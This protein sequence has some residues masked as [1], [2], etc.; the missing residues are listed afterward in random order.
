MIHA[1][2]TAKPGLETASQLPAHHCNDHNVSLAE[3]SLHQEL[4]HL[5]SATPPNHCQTQIHSLLYITPPMGILLR[6][7]LAN[8]LLNWFQTYSRDISSLRGREPLN[9][10]H[11]QVKVRGLSPLRTAKHC[12][13]NRTRLLTADTGISFSPLR[14]IIDALRF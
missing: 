8:I 10:G 2:M 4:T 3:Q 7:L 11:H 14:V 9:H 5:V 13:A 12:H 6:I 1:D